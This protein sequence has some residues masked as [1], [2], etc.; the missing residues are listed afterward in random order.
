MI[1]SLL[2]KALNLPIRKCHPKIDKICSTIQKLLRWSL[3]SQKSWAKC[4]QDLLV[5]LVWN[6][7]LSL[8]E[9]VQLLFRQNEFNQ[10]NKLLSLNRFKVW[11]RFWLTFKTYPF[12]IEN[13][14]FKNWVNSQIKLS[15]NSHHKL[16]LSKLHLLKL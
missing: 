12:L 15:L 4:Q 2:W 13:S 3:I 9:K 11:T 7:P 8:W 10:L 6:L 1:Q 14:F 16:S 5:I